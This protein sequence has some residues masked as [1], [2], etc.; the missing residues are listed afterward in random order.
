MTRFGGVV[1]THALQ[2]V[3]EHC[4]GAWEMLARP[5]RQNFLDTP[6]MDKIAQVPQ[7][8]NSL[9]KSCCSSGQIRV[10]WEQTPLTPHLPDQLVAVNCGVYDE[11]NIS[12]ECQV[13]GSARVYTANCSCSC[14]KVPN[15]EL[16]L[17]VPVTFGYLLQALAWVMAV[18]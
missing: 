12:C 8:G 1:F 3:S 18:I 7:G 6:P 5:P 15:E 9:V 17:H 11:I 4:N 16:L 10:P 2:G 13:T 14:V